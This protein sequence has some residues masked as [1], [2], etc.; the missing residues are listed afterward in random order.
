MYTFNLEDNCGVVHTIQAYGIDRISDHA[1]AVDLRQIKSIFPNAPSEAFDRP[2]GDIDILIGS[3][4]KNL[5]QYGGEEDYTKG[6]L[7]LLRSHFGGGFVLSGTHADIITEENT[8]CRSAKILVNAAPASTEDLDQANAVVVCNRSVVRPILPGFLE[9]EELGVRAPKS[10]KRCQGCKDC[11]FRAEMMSRDKELV[12]RRLEELIKYDAKSKTVSVSYPWTEDVKR[13]TD[14]VG[15][16]IAIQRSCERRLLKNPL[17]LDAYNTELRKSMERGAIVKLTEDEIDSYVGPVSY[18]AHHDVHKPDSTT[19]PL[20]VVTNTS[21]K[22]INAGLSPNDCMREG[23]N[24]LSSLL[25]V[26]IGFRMCEVGLVYDMSKAY[27][28]IKT[29]EV[30]KHV[31][32]LVWR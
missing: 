28:A 31:R 10:C 32:R 21:L 23:P 30:E 12:V 24:A 17:L 5:H 6:R 2:T 15:Q 19:T 9:A 25:E 7:R 1:R 18:V 20:R 16:A 8:L 11:S 13:L 3:M 4:Y 14:N 29:G 27:Q 26:L 22:N